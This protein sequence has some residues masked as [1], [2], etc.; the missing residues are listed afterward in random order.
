MKSS[1]LIDHSAWVVFTDCG[2]SD[3]EG[4]GGELGRAIVDSKFLWHNFM[5]FTGSTTCLKQ[6]GGIRL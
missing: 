3:R 5:G 4:P 1:G 2:P 6:L